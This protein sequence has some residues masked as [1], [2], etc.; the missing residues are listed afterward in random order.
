M[1]E[2]QDNNEVIA[3]QTT[4]PVIPP[5]VN[6]EMDN[7]LYYRIT[8]L[9][10]A[11]EITG[12][13][14]VEAVQNGVNVKFTL[15]Q[16]F[17][18]GKSA[19]ELAKELGYEGTLEDWLLSLKGEKGTDGIDGTNGT[20]G[21]DGTNGTDGVDGKDGLSALEVL[22]QGY[23]EAF[24]GVEDEL[25]VFV[26]LLRG[27]KGNDGDKGDKGD[28]GEQGL[29][30]LEVLKQ[31]FPESFPVEAVDAD[32]MVALLKGD[33]GDTGGSIRIAGSVTNVSE[34]PDPVDAQESNIA[35]YVGTNLYI[36]IEGAWEDF[37]DFSG[38]RGLGINIRGTLAKTEE[39]PVINNE[40]GDAFI[41]SGLK[42]M[43]VWD[44]LQW[45]E[46]GQVGPRGYDNYELAVKNGFDGEYADWVLTQLG[47]KGETGDVGPKGDKGDPAHAIR[48]LGRQESEATL[49]ESSEPGDGYFVGFNLFVYNGEYWVDCGELHA[50]SAYDLA[51]EMGFEGTMYEWL[52]SLQGLAGE[53]GDQGPV[54]PQGPTGPSLRLLGQKA[55]QEELPAVEEVES[56]GDAYLIGGEVFVCGSAGWFNAGLFRGPQGDKGD[57][58]ERGEQGAPGTGLVISGQITLT[59]ELPASTE[60]API[61][62]GT[63]Y[64]QAGTQNVFVFGV[65]GWFNAGPLRGAKGETGPRGYRG[66]QGVIGPRGYTGPR[67]PQGIRGPLGPIGPQ[68]PTGKELILSGRKATEQD[69][70]ASANIGT[71]F[72][73][74]SEALQEDEVWIFGVDGWFNA[75]LLRGP[76]GEK[77]D[78]GADGDVGPQGPT[79]KA[80][81]L[82]G[83]K[84]SIEELP[85]DEVT[86]NSWM[87]GEDIYFKEETGYVNL[88]PLRGLKG[89]TGDR[90]LKGDQGERGVQGLQG[91]G[92]R[93]MGQLASTNN[94]PGTGNTH[95]DAWII[96]QNVWIYGVTG[97][98]DA[99]FIGAVSAY[100]LY[101]AQAISRG[102]NPLSEQDW[103]ASLKG[104]KGERGDSGASIV[105]KGRVDSVELLP[106]DAQAND[107]WVIGL[108]VHVKMASG[109]WI[110]VGPIAGPRGDTG[111][112]GPTG[113]QG[114][115]GLRGLK[116]EPG[117]S[118]L[119][120][121]YDPQVAD[122]NVNDVFMNTV[123]QGIWIK[124]NALLWTFVGYF[125]G[126]NVY[127]PEDI[128][129]TY[130]W[131]NGWVEFNRYD[132]N[133]VQTTGELDI[134]V[135]N[136]FKI[137]N[138]TN[139][140][141]TV[142][143]TNL[144][145]DRGTTIVV[146][147]DGNVGTVIWPESIIWNAN[148]APEPKPTL[149]NVV[150]LYDGG[151]LIG[152]TGAS[153]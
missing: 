28:Q 140:I 48:V 40:P 83:K 82:Q 16:L 12:E 136:Y 70:P 65:Y 57:R 152:S 69:L 11:Q 8:D 71:A 150:F 58:G 93:V 50:K 26:S 38:P 142:S 23:P 31:A 78:K 146:L 151:R 62:V 122:G 64:V 141:K 114:I 76:Q 37:G 131:R 132:V 2:T 117:R 55:S 13:E 15:A 7:T 39:L 30:A 33:K 111:P 21:T 139:T 116:G 133:I 61:E 130:V 92:L 59:S 124:S 54:G 43:M 46:V 19:Y 5:A 99:G 32:S 101:S 143:F 144:P 84:N 149:T 85:A 103:I 134:G 27:E 108:D 135:S 90:G 20:D 119:I 56:L 125:G 49:P 100:A 94:L 88:G 148:T 35:F 112:Q 153:L 36:P 107:A 1:S 98:F 4:D 102:E 53:Q 104:E 110:N 29:S 86:G 73:I 147:I 81:N 42:I 106:E 137:D 63:A 80:L 115:T 68:G 118:V 96:G 52:E 89:D 121:P 17:V 25:A 123:T 77:G 120:G 34:L 74:K 127:K 41:I 95:G 113:K 145:V 66:E 3:E 47:P 97:F 129:K 6:P 91:T 109:E 138:T 22:K 72:V 24:A 51:V 128:T 87:V 60:E 10:D 75:G 126:G 18:A 44:G 14:V 9:P 67:G 105:V 79:G 45:S